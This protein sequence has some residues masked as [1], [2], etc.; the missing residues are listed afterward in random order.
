MCTYTCIADGS[1]YNLERYRFKLICPDR[2][3]GPKRL[4]CGF[5]SALMF[6][7]FPVALTGIHEL[8][9]CVYVCVCVCVCVCVF[10]CVCSSVAYACVCVS[11]QTRV[12]LCMHAHVCSHMIL[13]HAS[14]S[15]FHHRVIFPPR[16]SYRVYRI[17]Y[18]PFTLFRVSNLF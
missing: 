1:G 12:C 18:F 15:C 14:H 10:V 7:L 11:F 3:S 17:I 6:Q 9:V 2:F 4:R 16:Y 5:M 13:D 8:C